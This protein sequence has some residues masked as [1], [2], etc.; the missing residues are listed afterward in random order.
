MAVAVTDTHGSETSGGTNFTIGGITPTGSDTLLLTSITG[1]GQQT[2]TLQKFNGTSLTALATT[3]YSTYN[4]ALESPSTS[5]NLTFTLSGYA[6]AWVRAVAFSGVDIGGTP[7]DTLVSK[8]GTSVSCTSGTDTVPTDG[9]KYFTAISAYTSS[10][11]PTSTAGTAFISYRS[12][13]S[14]RSVMGGYR[15]TDGAVSWNL[16]GSAAWGGP[17][18]IVNPLAAGGTN[19]KGVFGLPFRGPFGGALA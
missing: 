17:S 3:Y 12:G 19:P 1:S 6:Q 13:A 7:Y 15:L 8:T 10:G 9:A 16:S 4:S 11:D 2:V 18:I 5:G 14:G